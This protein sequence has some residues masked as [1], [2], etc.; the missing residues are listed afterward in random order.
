VLLVDLVAVMEKLGEMNA[1]LLHSVKDK[2]NARNDRL[3][4]RNAGVPQH[5]KASRVLVNPSNS[6]RG[7]PNP[8]SDSTRVKTTLGSNKDGDADASLPNKAPLVPDNPSSGQVSSTY[9]S[10]RS[11]SADMDF[12]PLNP[13]VETDVG[14]NTMDVNMPQGDGVKV[15]FKAGR[16]H[17]VETNKSNSFNDGM[18]RDIDMQYGFVS[19]QDE[20]IAQSCDVNMHTKTDGN[21]LE[22]I[23]ALFGRSVIT[24]Q[25]ID[26]FTKND[27]GKY[28][29][30]AVLDKDVQDS[31][32]DA[33][34]ALYAEL[35][36]SSSESLL[37]I[38]LFKELTFLFLVTWFKRLVLV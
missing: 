17:T 26:I 35:K 1:E 31:I 29:L 37:W 24:I 28:P 14:L 8:N 30:W 27:D 19:S 25:D 18:N 33:M 4:E 20:P 6:V 38:L 9:G 2:I 36:T 22:Y 7:N 34:A 21:V 11:D 15:S 32:L 5:K 10:S 13:T 16:L 23:K 12:P 3:H